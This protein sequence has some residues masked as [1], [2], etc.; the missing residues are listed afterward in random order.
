MNTLAQMPS[1]N[2]NSRLASSNKS[3]LIE[4]FAI[5]VASRAFFLLIMLIAPNSLKEIFYLFDAEQY[6]NIAK[7]GYTTMMQTSFFPVVP[8]ILRYLG[9]A[10]LLIINNICFFASL[11]LLK[12]L[13]LNRMGL[14]IVAFSPIAFFSMLIYTESIYFFLTIASYYLYHER[15]MPLL[16]G[17]VMG[18]G[19]CT[20][21]S[22]AM[23]FFAIFIAMAYDWFN[24]KTKLKD[25]FTAYIP[26]TLISILFPAFLQI[27]FNNW[28][29][30][31]DSQYSDWI[32]IKTNLIKTFLIQIDVLFG[33]TM[34]KKD[35]E[36]RLLSVINEAIT[37]LITGLIIALVIF[38]IVYIVSRSRKE[39]KLSISGSEIVLLV[40]TVAT[41]FAF[42]T[43]IRNP[44]IDIPTTSFFRYYAS[45]FP[46]YLYINKR[47]ERA[48]LI[49][50]ALTAS[51]SLITSYFFCKGIYFY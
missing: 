26:A 34:F 19:V 36:L 28:K 9:S 25:I 4:A 47:G 7:D 17:I 50:F 31:V 35:I 2:K 46:I 21:N 11:Y 1:K 24:K 39:K 22:A 14:L 5:F 20:R 27:K 3:I 23:V 42:N 12:K 6:I 40:Y 8:L 44:E 15:K 29:A 51:I 43:T 32:K 33:D 41:F 48:Q 38:E 16:M 49:I 30:F 10:C 45:L 13:G 18:I 37:M